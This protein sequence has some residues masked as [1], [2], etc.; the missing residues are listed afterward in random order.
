MYSN[1]HRAESAYFK[2]KQTKLRCSNSATWVSSVS[3]G[4]VLACITVKRRGGAK[5]YL[6]QPFPASVISSH[7]EAKFGSFFLHNA[8]K[9]LLQNI[10]QREGADVVM[11]ARGN[12]NIVF[13]ASWIRPVTR[14]VVNKDY[15]YFIKIPL[16][17]TG[18]TIQWYVPGNSKKL[19][20]ELDKDM[21]KYY[22]IS[23]A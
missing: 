3:K 20:W 11:D 10:C 2:S 4:R 8:H 6:R 14:P 5:T 18:V 19:E 7:Q 13:N 21:L 17:H 12:R 1:F 23:S 15:R 9:T 16:A 22:T